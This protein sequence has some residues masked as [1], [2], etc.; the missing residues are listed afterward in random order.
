MPDIYVNTK[1]KVRWQRDL[2][3]ASS[4]TASRFMRYMLPN[5]KPIKKLEKAERK[6]RGSWARAYTEE[7]MREMMNA[8]PEEFREKACFINYQGTYLFDSEVNE[9]AVIASVM[10][11]AA[12]EDSK[13][14]NASRFIESVLEEKAWKTL[15]KPWGQIIVGDFA[16]QNEMGKLNIYHGM[17]LFSSEVNED[18]VIASVMRYA[19]RE[20]SKIGNASRFIESVLEEKAWKTLEKPEGQITVDD[21]VIKNEDGKLIYRGT[22]V[23]QASIKAKEVELA[24]EKE[25]H[26]A[27]SKAKLPVA[28][29]GLA[30][31]LVCAVCSIFG[32]SLAGLFGTAGMMVLIGVWLGMGIASLAVDQAFSKRERSL[33]IWERAAARVGIP[34]KREEN[35]EELHEAGDAAG[36]WLL[37]GQEN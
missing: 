15:E 35:E 37:P 30:T 17:H 27:S 29:V 36:R 18:A 31:F 3:P 20:D 23:E 16:V 26:K 33:A 1:C 6:S 34:P 24:V 10:R 25:K 2:K 4:E 5:L 13:I 22:L 9:D 28:L 14:G 32:V 12:R 8:C 19:A 21:F 11:Y 7:K